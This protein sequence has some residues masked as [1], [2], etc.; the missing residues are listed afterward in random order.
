MGKTNVGAELAPPVSPTIQIPIPCPRTRYQPFSLVF[1]L[2]SASLQFKFL[3]SYAYAFTIARQI[4]LYTSTV[5][6]HTTPIQAYSSAICPRCPVR[7]SYTVILV[8]LSPPTHIA[9][10]TQLR[11]GSD[12]FQTSYRVL[13]HGI[14]HYSATLDSFL[15]SP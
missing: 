5:I 4:A 9:A 2:P 8:T 10:A 6:T 13:E 11:T 1:P 12:T 14:D 3:L 7:L 15:I